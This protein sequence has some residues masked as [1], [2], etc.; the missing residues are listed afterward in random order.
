MTS[1]IEEQVSSPFNVVHNISLKYNRTTGKIEGIPE[2]VSEA[3]AKSGINEEAIMENPL[4]IKDLLLEIPLR[5]VL[6]ISAPTSFSHNVRI[7]YNKETGKF[8]GIPEE[9]RKAITDAGLTEEQVMQNPELAR[10]ILYKLSLS[11]VLKSTPVEISNPTNA[12][13]LFAIRFNK[14]TGKFEGI[15]EV[16]LKLLTEKGLTVEQCVQNPSLASFLYDLDLKESDIFGE[17]PQPPLDISGPIDACHLFAITMNKETGKLEGIPETVRKALENAGLT[18]EQVLQDPSLATEILTKLN[19]NDV[20]SHERVKNISEPT[21][22]AHRLSITINPHT[23]KFEGIP[24]AILKFITE[25]GLTVEQIASDINLATY[26]L[27]QIEKEGLLKEVPNVIDVSKPTWA[28]HNF[29]ITVNKETGKFEGIPDEVR[30]ALED[31]GLTEES[32]LNDPTRAAE[33]LSRFSVDDFKPKLNI[34]SPISSSHNISIKFNSE[35]GKFEGIPDEVRKAVL[36]AGLTEQQVLENPELA[37]DI[38]YKISLADV[39]K[40]VSV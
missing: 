23:G 29:A 16:I 20:V 32:V 36:D 11:D 5:P 12:R 30:K 25:R 24:D 9:V 6:E 1:L 8:E 22:F 19:F 17:Q 10:D 37:I 34:S 15:P 28:V 2:H 7:T 40:G 38:L 14:E 21:N 3:I 27:E 33:I 39:L 26:I 18:E 35:T 4:V 31:E 13:H